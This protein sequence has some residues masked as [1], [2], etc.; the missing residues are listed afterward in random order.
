MNENHPET[1][2][3]RERLQSFYE[4][5][6]D[7]PAFM[8][9]TY[10]PEFWTPI[11]QAISEIVDS[12]E[13]CRVLEFGAG[14]SGFG[15]FVGNLRQ[16]V[17]WEVQDITDQNVDFLKATA[18]AVHL[19]ELCTINHYFD[20]IFSTFVWEHLTNPKTT[21][22]HLLSILAP[23]GR[24]FLAAPR[25]DCPL[26][27]PPSARH[28]SVLH[29]L[30]LNAWLLWMRLHTRLVRQA[31]FYIHVDPAVLHRPWFRDAD[32]VH[33]VSLHDL[34]SELPAGYKLREV[35]LPTSG[36]RELVWNRFM[37]LF[38][39]IIKVGDGDSSRN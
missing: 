10:K 28:Y 14:R 8:E 32:A 21:F 3:L 12:G 11:R 22:R 39:E 18:D 23:G 26:Y 13:K 20:V 9:V 38:V 1:S 15:K 17:I 5:V 31:K 34:K 24:L 29:Q 36:V 35:P 27:F 4:S 30:F 16:K 6:S 33:W 7:Y 19:G 2:R 25:Y 37:L